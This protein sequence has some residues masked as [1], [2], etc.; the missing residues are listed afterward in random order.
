MLRSFS[1]PPCPV[2]FDFNAT[3]FSS[4]PVTITAPWPVLWFLHEAAFDWIA[5]DVA[6]LFDELRLR[7]DV[8]VVITR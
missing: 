1:F 4:E 7:E 2:G 3:S 6:K 8:E 5:M